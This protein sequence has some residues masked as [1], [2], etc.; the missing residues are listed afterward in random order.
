MYH[1]NIS[2]KQWLLRTFIGN[3]FN[4]MVCI[5]RGECFQF[6]VLIIYPP[7]LCDLY[8]GT[9]LTFNWVTDLL[10]ICDMVNWLAMFLFNYQDSSGQSSWDSLDTFW[11]YNLPC[12]PKALISESLHCTWVSFVYY[13]WFVS[14]QKFSLIC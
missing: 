8:I 1:W 4:G 12:F 6:S 11:R 9:S 14:M 3:M 2:F 7:V 5:A 13:F 10:Y